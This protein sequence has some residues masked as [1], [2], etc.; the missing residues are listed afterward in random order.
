MTAS[1]AFWFMGP[2]STM[3]LSGML[4]GLPL[5][6][7][8]LPE[9]PALVRAAPPE[10]LWYFSSAGMATPDPNSVNQT[11][12]LFAEEEVQAL[13]R[14]V[15]RQI[16]QAVRR[17]ARDRESRVLATEVPK[18]VKAALTRPM[19]AYVADVQLP[20]PGGPPSVRGAL[21]VSLEGQADTIGAALISLER[22]RSHYYE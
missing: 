1:A 22:D 17:G 13:A 18:L 20:G 11:E 3:L 9:D 2:L 19:I 15:E 12:Q 14:A 10:C 8:P 16:K 6:V 4:S 21:I 7:P 5:G